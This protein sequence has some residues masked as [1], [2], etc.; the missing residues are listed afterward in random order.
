MHTVN[1]WIGPAG[2]VTPLHTDPHHNM[3][4]QVVGY[5]YF[6]LFSPT[7]TSR[8]YPHE[9]GLTTNSS[10]VDAEA[11]DDK[12]FPLFKAATGLQ[13]FVQPGQALYIPP[14]ECQLRHDACFSNTCSALCEICSEAHLYHNG[15]AVQDGG[16]MSEQ[17]QVACL[18]PSGGH[19]SALNIHV[20]KGN[21][22]KS[23]MV[24]CDLA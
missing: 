3:F 5:K 23:A 7:E 17:R 10:R 18:F 21:C 8:M 15:N 4:V 24:S 16:T 1:A 13:F 22:L 9:S 11:P 6:Q 19:N 12:L 14:G 20:G 2:T